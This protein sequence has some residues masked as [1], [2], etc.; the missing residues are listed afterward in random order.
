MAWLGAV[1]ALVS[2]ELVLRK[3]RGKAFD[4]P[5]R[6]LQVTTNASYAAV[7]VALIETGQP[8]A[9][10]FATTLVGLTM[11]AILIRDFRAGARL[12][13]S[14]SPMIVAVILVQVGAVAQAI[15]QGRAALV[16]AIVGTPVLVAMMVFALRQDL[17]HA[18]AR[19][20]GARLAAEAAARAKAEFLANMSHEIR[21]PLSAVIG[22]GGLLDGIA[23]LPAEAQGHS[24]RIVASG[25]AL[26]AVVNDILDFSKMEAGQLAIDRQP[27]QARRFFE[28]SLAAFE[29]QASDKGLDLLLAVDP[30]T[31]ER[32]SLDV[33]RVGQVLSN[34]IGN[35]VK[36]TSAGS[37]T[38]R[39]SY[40]EAG[41]EVSVE[42]TGEGIPADKLPRLFQR[43]SQV[44]GSISRRHGGSGL[45]LS[46]CKGLVE[47]MDGTIDCRS[48]AGVR[49]TFSFRLPAAIPAQVKASAGE[50]KFATTAQQREIL[51]VDDLEPNR[52][53]IHALLEALGHQV[54]LA[55]SGAEAIKLCADRPFDL[56]FMDLQMPEMDGF[57]A[58]RAIRMESARNHAAPIVA[59]SAN[60]LAEHVEASRAAGMNDHLA[61]PICLADLVQMV[62]TWTGSPDGARAAKAA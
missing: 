30:E 11:F 36:F 57:E 18:R 19:L 32:L 60:V 28:D 37:V 58:A 14:L 42:D 46:I 44:D 45:G 20:T 41:L 40:R 12:F 48:E 49:S 16:P 5:R 52:V 24:R 53:L 31:P 25:A 15:S 29:P 35:A 7:A 4:L 43:F 22:F 62:E 2:G 21:T 9:E 33:T 3:G 23:G 34:L 1:A 13:I 38:V 59:L 6:G 61:K 17:V 51:V 47:L 8:I 50:A 56:I 27:V 54:A 55:A 10:V 39:V 26:L